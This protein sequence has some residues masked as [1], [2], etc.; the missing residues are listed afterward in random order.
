[1]LVGPISS[2]LF[3]VASKRNRVR[4]GYEKDWL[5][6]RLVFRAHSS[7]LF[8]ARLVEPKNPTSATKN[9]VNGFC[10]SCLFIPTFKRNQMRVGYGNVGFV[11]DYYSEHQTALL[12][13]SNLVAPTSSQIPPTRFIL[14]PPMG[15]TEKPLFLLRALPQ[16]K[17]DFAVLIAD[18]VCLEPVEWCPSA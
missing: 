4:E 16:K 7:I 8:T 3:T 11:R 10:F 1:M 14:E 5:C 13:K 15:G 17:S 9:H 18:A 2:S 12:R 6:A